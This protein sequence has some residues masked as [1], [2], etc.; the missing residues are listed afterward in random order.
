MI[1]FKNITD[2]EALSKL[3]EFFSIHELVDKAT[4]DKYGERA[5]DFMDLR[6]VRNLLF[7]RVKLGKSITVNNW[8]WGGSLSQRGLRTNTSYIVKKKTQKDSIYLSAHTM[9]KAVDFDV[10]G[11]TANE[12]REWI[13]SNSG[14]LPYPCRLERKLNGNY[15]TWVHLDVYYNPSL[16]KVYLF[17]V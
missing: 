17:D 9:F 6:L 4:Y 5:W 11:M 1:D 12:V 14:E 16:P 3:K 15:I 2:E 7:I 13:E 10:D 8:K